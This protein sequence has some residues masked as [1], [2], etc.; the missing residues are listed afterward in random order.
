MCRG[1]A[2]D[3]VRNGEGVAH[4]LRVRVRGASEP[5]ALGL[6]KA[7]VNSPLVKTA[8][9]GND[10]NVGRILSSMGDYLAQRPG[11]RG[12]ELP[13]AAGAPGRHPTVREAGPSAWI[14]PRSG[15]WP[16]T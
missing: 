5:L 15:A 9:C 12:G 14:R 11:R 2:E 6:G 16:A 4:V 8:V 7:V 10:P 3:I 13:A 1:L